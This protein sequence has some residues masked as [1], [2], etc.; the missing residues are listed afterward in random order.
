MAGNA[1]QLRN[2]QREAALLELAGADRGETAE[3]LGVSTKTVSRWRSTETYQA[4]LK[5]LR[6]A[7]PD[8]ADPASELR[9]QIQLG[10]AEATRAVR[11]LLRAEMQRDNPNPD[12]I[13]A[14]ARVLVSK[15]PSASRQA[16]QP[17]PAA[18]TISIGEDGVV[19]VPGPERTGT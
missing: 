5:E 14:I 11:D 9:E 7:A 19:T 2:R 17:Q 16:V 15:A 13:T 12:V 18:L 4:A 1:G 8:A 10:A 6:S 3:A